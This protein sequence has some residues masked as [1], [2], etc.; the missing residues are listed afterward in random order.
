MGAART[1][2]GR[3]LSCGCDLVRVAGPV[4]GRQRRS[5]LLLHASNDL[6]ETRAVGGGADIDRGGLPRSGMAD[7]LACTAQFGATS[8]ASRLPP[9]AFDRSLPDQTAQLIRCQRTLQRH[10]ASS[11]P[12]Q[13]SLTI[14]RRRR[15]HEGPSLG[16]PLN[17]SGQTLASSARGH[18]CVWNLRFGGNGG[19]WQRDRP[20][21]A[22]FGLPIQ[23][24]PILGTCSE[25]PWK[26]ACET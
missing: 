12:C 3:S 1:G 13:P 17:N 22:F 26:F 8:V 14:W 25:N 21:S 18:Q 24:A 19:Q 20:Q 2:I 7:F 11:A 23:G 10:D 5:R 6:G 16:E 4:L 9:V 15:P